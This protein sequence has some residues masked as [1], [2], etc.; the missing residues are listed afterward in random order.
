[1]TTFAWIDLE[2]TGLNPQTDRILEFAM[3][4][5]DDQLRPLAEP[6]VRALG[7]HRQAVL[8][9]FIVNMHT[10]S[11]LLAECFESTIDLGVVIAEAEQRLDGAGFGNFEKK[12]DRPIIA[13]SSIHFDKGFLQAHAPGFLDKFH[14]RLFDVSMLKEFAR[15]YTPSVYESRP[16]P[17]MTHRALPDIRYTMSE[18]RHYVLHFGDRAIP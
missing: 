10:K 9:P 11:G 4:L 13:G 16:K 14:Y 18:L 3:V 6:V 7:L 12:E 17:A 5:T 1:M 8:D 2:T 15:A